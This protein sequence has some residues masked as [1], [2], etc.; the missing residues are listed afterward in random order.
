M[1][2]PDSEAIRRE[3]EGQIA[4]FIRGRDLNGEPFFREWPWY[5]TGNRSRES[6][7][8]KFADAAADAIARGVHRTAPSAEREA[9]MDAYQYGSLDNPALM[10]YGTDPHRIRAE[11]I[12]DAGKAIDKLAEQFRAEARDSEQH[13]GGIV[14][15]MTYN[16]TLAQ[17]AVLEIAARVVRAL[18]Q[19]A[20]AKGGTKP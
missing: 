20:E 15:G 7:I 11:V 1:T 19:P 18:A 8:T 10:N 5:G 12:E 3:V 16:A 9:H 4:A 14:A 17:V 2:T 13:P 6:E